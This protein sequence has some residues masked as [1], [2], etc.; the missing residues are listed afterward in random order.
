VQGQK[1]D[2]LSECLPDVIYASE[3]ITHK[4]FSRVNYTSDSRW[5]LR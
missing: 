3:V 5:L 1:V 2:A 4:L